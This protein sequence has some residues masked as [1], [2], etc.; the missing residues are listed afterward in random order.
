MFENATINLIERD[1]GLS[2]G[3]LEETDSTCRLVLRGRQRCEN[4]KF[5]RIFS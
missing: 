5:S 4:S 2:L 3:S 1:L